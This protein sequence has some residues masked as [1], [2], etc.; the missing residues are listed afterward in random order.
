MLSLI[1][2]YYFRQDTPAGITVDSAS[3]D[4]ELKNIRIY[5]RAPVSYTHLLSMQLITSP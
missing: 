4:V 3:A 5:N 2:I 1:H